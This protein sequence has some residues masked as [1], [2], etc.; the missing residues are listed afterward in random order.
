MV[1]SDS[2]GLTSEYHLEPAGTGFSLGGISFPTGGG[3][4]RAPEGSFGSAAREAASSGVLDSTGTGFTGGRTD[5]FNFVSGVG[6]S[7]AAAMAAGSDES[8]CG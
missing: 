6:G 5:S 7:D 3:T 8:A 1:F 2:V 4:I